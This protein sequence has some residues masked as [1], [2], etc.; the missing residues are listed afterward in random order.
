[1]CLQQ[2]RESG[3][4]GVLPCLAAWWRQPGWPSALERRRMNSVSQTCI[5]TGAT[6]LGVFV[7]SGRAYLVSAVACFRVQ[8]A[9]QLGRGIGLHTDVVGFTM[10]VSLCVCRPCHCS[11]KVFLSILTSLPGVRVGMATEWVWESNVVN[12]RLRMSLLPTKIAQNADVM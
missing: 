10:C 4:N 11:V 1:M 6:S 5:T 3:L 9:Q 12:H 8:A 2:P 7:L